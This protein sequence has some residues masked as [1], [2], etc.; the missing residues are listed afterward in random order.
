M[1]EVTAQQA[2]Q[3]VKFASDKSGQQVGDGEC[4]ALAD[5][6]LKAAG[7]KSADSYGKI[8]PT[9][10]YVWGKAETVSKARGGDIV[11][12]KDY[13]VT[14]TVVTKISRADGSSEERIETETLSRPHHT[15]VVSQ[16]G[17]NGAVTVLEQ[18]VNGSRA[19]QA[20]QLEFVSHDD[21][22]QTTSAGGTT[23]TVI[24]KVKVTGTAKF[25]RPQAK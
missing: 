9:A 14:V 12:F 19:V 6:A 17:S 2:E 24:R 20:N 8:T 10:D 23:T 16:T 11:Q 7:A 18:N 13:T 22:P 15:A 3:T 25:Y 4:Y 21:P 5:E 1:P